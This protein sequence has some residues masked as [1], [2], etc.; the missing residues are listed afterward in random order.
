[1]S[2]VFNMVGGGGGSLNPSDALIHV[3]APYGSTVT[4]A[5]GGVVAKTI[6][7]DKAFANV[8]GT[9]ADYYYP[10]KSANYGTW[11]VTATLGQNTASTTLVVS[12]NMQYNIAL[13][14]H[15]SSEYQEVE[16]LESTGTQ[17]INSNVQAR[18]Q[19]RMEYDFQYVKNNPTNQSFSGGNDYY[20]SQ[21]SANYGGMNFGSNTIYWGYNGSWIDISSQRPDHYRHYYR[22]STQ[23]GDQY[24]ER[25]GV[26]LSTGS[27]SL[28]GTTSSQTLYLFSRY[29][30]GYPSIGRLY[31]CSIYDY[32]DGGNLIRNFYPCYRK[33]DNVAGLYDNVNGVFYANA[34]SGTFIVGPDVN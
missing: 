1:M 7:P 19:L 16:Y 8:D 32:L 33:S 5:K 26:K 30:G 29:N 2:L 14:Y 3:N 15:V 4:F 23:N 25:D 21:S 28:T 22:V 11:T 24:F 20:P 10:V 9:T 18:V 17:Y 34:G 13:S 12:A 6:T 31:S 27:A